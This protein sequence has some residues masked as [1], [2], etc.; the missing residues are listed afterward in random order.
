[1]E[2]FKQNGSD[3]SIQISYDSIQISYLADNLTAYIQ[4]QVSISSQIS[5][6]YFQI[7]SIQSQINKTTIDLQLFDAKIND[8]LSVENELQQNYT[9]Y[10][11]NLSL[12]QNIIMDC[13]MLEMECIS[14]RF[15]CLLKLRVQRLILTSNILVNL[16]KNSK[17]LLK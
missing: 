10:D 5:D 14:Q 4:S 2:K 1:M 17:L 9:I 6:L 11:D 15:Y 3:D 12:K 8:I 16:Q 13:S 7:S